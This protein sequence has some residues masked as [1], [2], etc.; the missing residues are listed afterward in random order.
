MSEETNTAE[1]I[2][3]SSKP[4]KMSFYAITSLVLLIIVVVLS[5]ILIYKWNPNT[6]TGLATSDVKAMTQTELKTHLQTQLDKMLNGQ[7]K[8]T[9]GAVNDENGVY[10]VNMTLDGSQGKQDFIAYVT[11]DGRYMFMQAVDLNN[12]PEPAKPEPAVKSDKP[13]V[14]LFVM[15]YCPYGLQEEKA[16]LPAWALL[17]DKADI[18]LKFVSYSMHGEK[19]VTENLRQYCI[20]KDQNDK[21]IPYLTCFVQSGNYTDCLKNASIDMTKL[22][23][24]YNATDAKYSIMANLNNKSTWL[25][26][27]PPFDI[28][29]ELNDLYGV[30]GSP[31]LVINGKSVTANRDPEDIKKAICD[32]FNNAPAECSTTLSKD[33]AAPGIGALDAKSTS[34][35]QASCG[36]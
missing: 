32:A 4:K 6:T 2:T 16:M 9:L 13:T 33:S 26:Q 8:V 31:T 24:C 25:G 35:I 15:S 27:F 10:A 28:D 1:T 17:K 7:A 20:Q 11:K 30:Q 29:K 12:I 19:E 22:D 18:S 14:D 3:I 23:A 21:F 5:G 34:D 36:S